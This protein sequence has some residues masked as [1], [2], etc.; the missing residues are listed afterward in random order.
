MNKSLNKNKSLNRL[1]INPLKIN[2][3]KKLEKSEDEEIAKII[4]N[5]RQDNMTD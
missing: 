2:K 4:F 1:L 3:L 5:S